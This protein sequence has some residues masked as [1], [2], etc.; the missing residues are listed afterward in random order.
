MP[1]LSVEPA[2]QWQFGNLDRLREFNDS[3][4]I[5]S[6]HILSRVLG[7]A[8]KFDGSTNLAVEWKY[9]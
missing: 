9:L 7:L 1:L 4:L 6:T 5:L 8:S 2:A 3:A